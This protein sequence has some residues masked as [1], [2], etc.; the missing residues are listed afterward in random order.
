MAAAQTGRGTARSDGVAVVGSLNVDFVVPAPRLPRPGETVLGG[1]HLRNPGG[2][3]ANQAVAAARMGRQVSMI[4][5]VGD[6][7]LGQE[8]LSALHADGI[9]T[10]GIAGTSD[11]PTGI[12]L[13]AVDRDG[14]NAI[15]VSP[16]ANGR[17]TPG[18]VERSRPTLEAAA[19]TLL[20]LE[21]PLDVVTAAA[22]FAGGTVVLNPAPA[23]ELPH[24][25]LATVDVIVPNRLEL[26]AL[27]GA[28]VPGEAEAVIACARRLEGPK[29]AV[30]T[31]GADGAIIVEGDRHLLVPPAAVEA[32][33]TTAAG[34]A[35]CGAIADALARGR[36]LEAA[37]HWAVRVA[38]VTVSRWGAQASLPTR[39]EVEQST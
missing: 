25:L 15:V 39:E 19:V 33:D 13:I 3:G 14:E 22:G 16:G 5:C 7:D 27:V 23:R 26:T 1:D 2:K 4:G 6:D 28:D 32:V 31:L 20:Q 38:G 18:Q 21:V 30:V 37:A 24:E 34:D 17:L 12:A 11:A 8:L 29:A 36:S 9:D 10:S 35:F